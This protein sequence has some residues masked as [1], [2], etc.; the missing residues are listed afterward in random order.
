MFFGFFH[1]AVLL[2]DLCLPIIF[3]LEAPS[4]QMMKYRGSVHDMNTAPVHSLSHPVQTVV[5]LSLNVAS[6]LF[7][8]PLNSATVLALSR[9]TLSS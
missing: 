4:T 7:L 8:L 2:V 9:S 3:E 1:G 5:W 6:L